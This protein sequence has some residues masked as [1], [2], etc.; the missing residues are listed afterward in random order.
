MIEN[1]KEYYMLDPQKLQDVVGQW[2]DAQFGRGNIR[3]TLLHLKKEVNELIESPTD[4]EE[5]ADCLMLLIDAGR[6]AG[7]NMNTLFD[8]VQYKLEINKKRKW[9][10]PD[11]NGI[12]EH[13]RED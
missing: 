11:E 5:H 13:I 4:G 2:S 9:G 1:L 3:S 7:F 12:V 10:K 6:K 8:A